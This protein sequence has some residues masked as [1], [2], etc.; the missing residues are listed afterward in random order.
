MQIIF[1]GI[2]LLVF[3]V[4][5]ITLSSM[6]MGGW[7]NSAIIIPLVFLVVY[8]LARIQPKEHRSENEGKK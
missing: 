6:K 3:L 5:T 4:V 8:S 7:L 1:A 2:S